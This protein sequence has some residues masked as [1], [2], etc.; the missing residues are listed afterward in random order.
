MAETY[1]HQCAFCVDSVAPID[2]SSIPIIFDSFKDSSDYDITDENGITGTRSHGKERVREGAGKVGF[3]IG[4]SFTPTSMAFFL[5][6]AL[7]GTPSGTSYAL[8]EALPSFVACADKKAKVITYTGCKVNK[9]TITGSKGS[10]MIKAAISVMGTGLSVGNAG[11]FPSLTTPTD[12]PYQFWDAVL[13]LVSASR[14]M[15]DFTLEIDNMLQPNEANEQV[16]SELNPTDR[17][18]TLKGTSPFNST[19]ISLFNQSI[20]GAAGSLVFTN[21]NYSTTFDF[22]NLKNK[23]LHPSIGGKTQRVPLNLDMQ[24][25]QSGSTKELVVT[26][27]S[28]G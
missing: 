14:Q 13:T 6:Y 23:R 12:P 11:T 17:I 24:A 4:L 7:G 15:S 21:G 1:G 27:D 3:D 26:H 5:Q 19:E 22:A 9:M 10:P 2:T 18:I 8:A 20:D 28:T 25:F 16:A